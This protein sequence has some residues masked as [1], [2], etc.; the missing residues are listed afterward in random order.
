MTVATTWGQ[1]IAIAADVATIGAVVYAGLTLNH[2]ALDGRITNSTK[3]LEQG[4]QLERDYRDG[5]AKVGDVLAF[6]HQVDLYHRNDRLLDEVF[7]PL[8]KSMCT[9][10]ATD[11]RVD[12]YWKTA[13]K[14]YG[15]KFEHMID[16][17][18]ESKKCD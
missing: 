4:S 18:L 11:P 14:Y 3:L 8:N 6:Y 12:E 16:K 2:S 9:F 17:I 15:E 5:K 7:V 10:V 13:S 1:R